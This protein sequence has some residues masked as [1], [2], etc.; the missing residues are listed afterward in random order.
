MGVDPLGYFLNV[1]AGFCM[2]M[3]M[4]LFRGAMNEEGRG[5]GRSGE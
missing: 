5:G 4:V 2:Y 1:F 3:T